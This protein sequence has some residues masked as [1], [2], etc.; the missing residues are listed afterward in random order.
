MLLKLITPILH[1]TPENFVTYWECS[2]KGGL[3]LELVGTSSLLS[4][5]KITYLSMTSA[6]QVPS[7]PR[8]FRPLLFLQSTQ[9]HSSCHDGKCPR[10][11][12]YLVILT[13]KLFG[14]YWRD[15]WQ[16]EISF[17]FVIDFHNSGRLPLTSRMLLNIMMPRKAQARDGPFQYHQLIWDPDWV[18]SLQSYSFPQH[19]P[20]TLITMATCSPYLS[21]TCSYFTQ[22]GP[23]LR[24]S[25]VISRII[26]VMLWSGFRLL[27]PGISGLSLTQLSPQKVGQDE[28][29]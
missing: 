15:I 24:G 23:L 8:S 2:G 16:P 29:W 12:S 28:W 18:E 14:P 3:P 27:S 17:C 5:Y 6:N 21:V 7:L 26:N 1:L 25:L 22:I 4:P 9:P 10:V 11:R 20:R 13:C 19:H